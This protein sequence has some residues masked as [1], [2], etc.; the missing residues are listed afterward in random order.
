MICG[1]CGIEID[2]PGMYET[3][4]TC[5]KI[6]CFNCLKMNSASAYSCVDCILNEK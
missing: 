3:C 4:R 5:G 6:L 1:M 2:E